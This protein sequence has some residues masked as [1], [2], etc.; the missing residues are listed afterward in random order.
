MLLARYF[1]EKIQSMDGFEVG[2]F[3]DLSVVTFRLSIV[4]TRQPV[5]S[6]SYH[7]LE[8]RAEESETPPPCSVYSFSS[9]LSAPV[10]CGR[11]VGGGPTW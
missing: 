8:F 11:C 6:R 5:Q 3:P 7:P 2:P 1:Y 4:K 9:S 10:R